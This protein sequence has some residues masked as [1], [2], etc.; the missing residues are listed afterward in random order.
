MIWNANRIFIGK[1]IT[2]KTIPLGSISLVGD[3]D[4]R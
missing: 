4:N 2:G 3:P 1:R